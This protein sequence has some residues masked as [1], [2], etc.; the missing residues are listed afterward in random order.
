MVRAGNCFELSAVTDVTNWVQPQN[1]NDVINAA[2][3]DQYARNVLLIIAN[4]RYDT[5]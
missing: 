3:A 2:D 5:Q 4:L 1:E